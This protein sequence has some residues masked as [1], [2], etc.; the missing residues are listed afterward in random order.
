MFKNVIQ[1]REAL[2]DLMGKPSSLAVNKVIDC[3][4]EHCK[5]FIAKSPFIVLA[6]SNKA[7]NAD[8]SPR[9]DQPGFVSVL[10]QKH[11][12]IPERM[13]NKRLDSLYNLLENPQVGILF[14]IPGSRETLRINGKASIVTDQELLYPLA[15]SNSIPSV[16]IGVKVEECFLHCGKAI[17]RSNLWEPSSWLA[18][19][20]MPKAGEILAAH[21]K[22]AEKTKEEIEVSLEESYI[23]RL[24]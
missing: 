10:D 4:D 12:L 22:A 5:T 2:Q 6:T 24:Y 3:L 14:L 18:L 23:K 8:A 9:G 13:G 17:I 1:T 11:L 7:G 19:D 20:D 16:G 21:A 15:A